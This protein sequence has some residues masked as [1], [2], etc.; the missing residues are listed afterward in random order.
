MKRGENMSDGSLRF[1][2]KVDDSEVKK[3]R[4]DI[5]KAF[6]GIIQTVK[7][8]ASN[9]ASA[10]SNMSSKQ[11]HYTNELNKTNDKLKEYEANMEALKNEK[12]PTKEYA[13]LQ[14]QLKEAEKIHQDLLNKKR[15]YNEL[16]FSDSQSPTL[17]KNIS[18]VNNEMNQIKA[19]MAELRDAGQA[20][21]MSQ[22][23]VEGISRFRRHSSD[24]RR[25]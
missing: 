7:R 17:M 25:V 22:K 10:L 15:E 3:S 19:K 14:E 4:S 8:T 16:G 9:T 21:T 2:T 11:L 12:I 23:S 20:E 24:C 5:I 13:E 6:E 18:T 1:D